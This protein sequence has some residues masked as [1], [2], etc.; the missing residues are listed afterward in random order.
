MPRRRRKQ[1]AEYAIR[2]RVSDQLDRVLGLNSIVSLQLTNF[3]SKAVKFVIPL[4]GMNYCST[5][6]PKRR[7]RRSARKGRKAART[8]KKRRSKRKARKGKKSTKKKS[9]RRRKKKAEYA[10]ELI[11]SIAYSV[12]TR[13]KAVKFV[14]P[15]EGM[16][17]CSTLAPKRRARRSARKGRKAARTGKKRRSKRKARKG[18][19]STKKKSRRRRKKKAE[20]A[21]ELAIN[22]IAYSVLTRSGVRVSWE[23]WLKYF[24]TFLRFVKT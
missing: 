7:A 22:S 13:S 8:G 6:A 20:Y 9:R 11:N 15:L 1:K 17:Y 4:E 18:K 16:N 21:I 2:D 12:L 5:L 23:S 14:I 3:R 10:I 19:K 24:F